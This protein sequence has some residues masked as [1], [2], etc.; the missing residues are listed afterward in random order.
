M[1]T[2]ETVRHILERRLIQY[3]FERQYIDRPEAIRL[4]K[5]V[6]Y[7]ESEAI[8][9]VGG[10]LPRVLR[11]RRKPSRPGIRRGRRK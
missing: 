4:L 11:A 5:E 9:I 7:P 10:W 6:D 1:K 8:V 3:R 2:K